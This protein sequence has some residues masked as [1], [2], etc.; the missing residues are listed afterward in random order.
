MRPSVSAKPEFSSL[1][2]RRNLRL[3][4]RKYSAHYYGNKGIRA[5]LRAGCGTIE[6]GSYLNLESIDMMLKDN[7]MLIPN[8]SLL[9]YR[10]AP[11]GLHQRHLR[12]ASKNQRDPPKILRIGYCS[13][14]MQSPWFNPSE[15]SGLFHYNS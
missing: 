14:C 9:E 5:A 4:L 11:R 12:E 3:T 10:S 6:R 13:G 8:P 15:F 1:V 7:A 2:K